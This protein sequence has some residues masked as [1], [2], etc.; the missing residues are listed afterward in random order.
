MWDD[1]KN[2]LTNIEQEYD[3]Y[4]NLV[5][6]FYD[7]KIVDEIKNFK[8]N[9]T[10]V[11]SENKGVAIGGFLNMIKLIK[12]SDLLLLLHTKKS[13]GL[14][15]K[16]SDMVR[17]YGIESAVKKGAEWHNKIMDGILK[18][19]TQ[20]KEI[21]ERFKNDEMCAMLGYAN[22]ENYVGPNEFLLKE[23][24]KIFNLNESVYGSNFVDGA[25][26]WVRFDIIKKYFTDEV[27]DIILDMT[28]PGY[29]NEPSINHVV[30]RIFGYIIKNE[31]KKIIVI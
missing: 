26:F 13:I 5:D 15:N 22:K 14:P 20:V 8:T 23:V 6:G 2:R 4:V 21:V 7:E 18:N 11:K 3:L 12:N 16:P 24:L 25:M 31:N 19:K 27:I 17:V 29:L 30:E 9:V 1:I 28:P 10:I